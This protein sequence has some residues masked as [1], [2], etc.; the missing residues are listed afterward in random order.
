MLRLAHSTKMFSENSNMRAARY[1]SGEK[2]EEYKGWKKWAKMHLK[3]KQIQEE[4]RGPE[5]YCL[6]DG[7]AVKAVED[8]DDMDLEQ[9]GGEQRIFDILDE[10]YPDAEPHDRIAEALSKVHTLRVEK[11]E[12]TAVYVG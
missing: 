9:P 10:R 3:A 11:E 4:S 2:P 7:E 6:L 5:I 12:K 8:I 1:F